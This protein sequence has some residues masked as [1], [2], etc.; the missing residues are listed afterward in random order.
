[1]NNNINTDKITKS[2]QKQIVKQFLFMQDLENL[3]KYNIA[4][5]YWD[6]YVRY[7][8]L[9]YLFVAGAGKGKSLIINSFYNQKYYSPLYFIQEDFTTMDIAGSIHNKVREGFKIMGIPEMNRLETHSKNAVAQSHSCILNITERKGL[10]QVKYGKEEVPVNPAIRLGIIGGITPEVFDRHFR[11]WFEMGLLNRFIVMTFTLSD[12]QENEIINYYNNLIN[13]SIKDV[14]PIKLCY[15]KT[16]VKVDISEL[17]PL[18]NLAEVMNERLYNKYINFL[19]V[20][21]KKKKKYENSLLDNEDYNE[22]IKEIKDRQKPSIIRWQQ[23]LIM[24]CVGKV[25]SEYRKEIIKSDIDEIIR[26]I[27]KYTSLNFPEVD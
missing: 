8:Q 23:K 7:E 24:L 17:K 19:K 27:N 3:I 14:N 5:T 10:C 4:S 12:K 20:N 18:T 16:S 15:K 21:H 6:K 26:L 25:I 9:S 22:V 11:E 1:M 13:S 2:E